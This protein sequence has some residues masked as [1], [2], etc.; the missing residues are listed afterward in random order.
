MKRI[1][2]LGSL[3]MCAVMLANCKT[4]E[5]V[6]VHHYHT[7]TRTTKSASVSKA[8]TPEGFQAVTPPSSYSR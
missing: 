4:P 8:N 2:S 5:P 6:V 1:L 7:P 3:A